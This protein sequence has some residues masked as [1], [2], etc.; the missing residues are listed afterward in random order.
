MTNLPSPYSYKDKYIAIDLPLLE[1]MPEIIN[2]GSGELLLKSEFHISLVKTSYVAELVHSISSEELE[3]EII[4]LFADF[5]KDQPLDAYKL[6]KQFRL[7]ELDTRKTIIGLVNVPHLDAFFESLRA[8][9][10]TDIP[11]QPTHITLYTL[12]P[13]AGIGVLSQEQM[14]KVSAAIDL[15]E[16]ENLRFAT[17]PK[18]R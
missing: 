12:Q 3:N 9:Y 7:V 11:V 16:F 1:Q 5:I 10:I 18:N 8:K 13:D 15:P 2:V 17:A 6:L 14:D 4:Q